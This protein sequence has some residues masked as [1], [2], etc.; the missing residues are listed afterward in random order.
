MLKDNWF[1]IAPTIF[2]M[3][4]AIFFEVSGYTFV[5]NI[6]SFAVC[7]S[8]HYRQSISNVV[9]KITFNDIKTFIKFNLCGVTYSI[10]TLVTLTFFGF[11][12]LSFIINFWL[13]I[14]YL[15]IKGVIYSIKNLDEVLELVLAIA[16]IPFLLVILMAYV[17]SWLLQNIGDIVFVII[18]ITIIYHIVFH[19]FI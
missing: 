9:L 19:I 8:L 16:V 15:A 2:S 11:T 4:V 13:I 3:L 12:E 5:T 6:L 10:C 17:T 18:T 1:L 7:F 14:G